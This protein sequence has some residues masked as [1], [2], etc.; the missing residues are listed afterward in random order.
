MGAFRN[1]PSKQAKMPHHLNDMVHFGGWFGLL[2]KLQ[3]IAK[4]TLEKTQCL[5][6]NTPQPNAECTPPSSTFSLFLTTA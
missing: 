5:S 3:P 2:N 6:S 1:S 4:C